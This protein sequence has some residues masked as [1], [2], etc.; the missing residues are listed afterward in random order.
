MAHVLVIDDYQDSADSLAM[1]LRLNGHEVDIAQDGASGLESADA[2]W[3]DVVILDIA[4][5][6]M[7]GFEIAKR[8]KSKSTGKSK[9]LLIAV[10][11]YGDD[12]LM[13][14]C[15]AEGFDRHI[16]K[17]ADLNDL[18]KSIAEGTPAPRTLSVA[19]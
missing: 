4:L 17:P 14:R 15:K 7:D 10:T 3:P 8:L 2:N 19:V 12:A 13:L 6:T 11:G 18:L 5:P 16:L 1:V 9:P